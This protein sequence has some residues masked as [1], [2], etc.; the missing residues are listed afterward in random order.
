MAKEESCEIP[1]SLAEAGVHRAGPPGA[2]GRAGRC[3]A[4]AEADFWLWRPEGLGLVA[5]A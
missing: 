2:T 3:A 4:L 1:Q 5:A